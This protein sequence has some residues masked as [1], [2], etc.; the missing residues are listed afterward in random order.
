MSANG[1]KLSKL[2]KA[3]EYQLQ[4]SR[5]LTGFH[6]YVRELT[7]AE[8][9]TVPTDASKLEFVARYLKNV[10]SPYDSGWLKINAVDARRVLYK[11]LCDS[12]AYTPNE[13]DKIFEPPSEA[14]DLTAAYGVL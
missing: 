9:R 14:K 7:D 1:D 6:Y 11:M 3:M 8:G 12:V 10:G 4:S 2:R 13:L 5:V